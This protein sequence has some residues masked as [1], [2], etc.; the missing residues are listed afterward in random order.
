MVYSPRSRPTSGPSGADWA[1]ISSLRR[2]LRI[3]ILRSRGSSSSCLR[4]RGDPGDGESEDDELLLRLRFVDWGAGD[5][6][7][8]T[9]GGGMRLSGVVEPDGVSEPKPS[10]G[11]GEYGDVACMLEPCG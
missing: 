6:D 8:D 7:G 4:E 9:R 5:A 10:T 2:R 3:A 1:E 11:R